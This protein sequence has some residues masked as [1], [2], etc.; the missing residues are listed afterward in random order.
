MGKGVFEGVRTNQRNRK[1]RLEFEY[2]LIKT[3]NQVSVFHFRKN[4]ISIFGG[5]KPLILMQFFLLV[6]SISRLQ[7]QL[8][9]CQRSRR[10]LRRSGILIQLLN[11]FFRRTE[12][13]FK[14][15]H[16]VCLPSLIRNPRLLWRPVVLSIVAQFEIQLATQHPRNLGRAPFPFLFQICNELVARSALRINLL[17]CFASKTQKVNSALSFS[18]S[19]KPY[20]K[21]PSSSSYFSLFNSNY[22]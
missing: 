6:I 18:C 10:Q 4:G 12:R 20:K 9:I 1:L 21:L 17:N 14:N 19:I 3:W 22:L 16:L 5:Q 15:H 2:Y 11:I 13:H 7:T 8:V